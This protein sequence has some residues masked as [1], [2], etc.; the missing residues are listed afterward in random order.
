MSGEQLETIAS[1]VAEKTESWP[2]AEEISFADRFEDRAAEI[3]PKFAHE[4]H[5]REHSIA[6]LRKTRKSI[7]GRLASEGHE[8]VPNLFFKIAKPE[9]ILSEMRGYRLANAYPHEA[10]LSHKIT[11]EYGIYIQM[12]NHDML[13]AGNLLQTEINRRLFDSSVD[14]ETEHKIQNLMSKL[15]ALYRENLTPAL[16]YDGENDLFFIDRLKPGG[17]IDK[18]YRGKELVFNETSISS[19]DLFTSQLSVNGK[20][21]PLTLNELFERAK[22]DLTPERPRRFTISPGDPTEA[23]MTLNG[24]F[25]DFE[26]GGHNALA[27]DLA[28]FLNYNFSGGHY[29][30]SKYSLAAGSTEAAPDEKAQENLRRFE[31]SVRATATLTQSTGGSLTGLDISLELP[32]PE[33]KARILNEYIRNVVRPLE[34]QLSIQERQQLAREL[35]SALLMRIMGVKNVMSF[36][37][38][39]QLAS[40]GLVAHFMDDEVYDSVE[41]YIES[42]FKKII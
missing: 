35:Q 5:F 21:C 23:N 3:V 36:T 11:Q 28:I 41:E 2:P 4:A 19:N 29:I 26:V 8:R 15:G 20:I 25:F 14:E 1:N 18:L 7:F 9:Q 10:V 34:A 37:Q 42:K 30:V 6:E 12:F 13:G 16:T 33:I 32:V 24:T 39:D 40:L 17:R 27:Q 22:L 38:K 31:D